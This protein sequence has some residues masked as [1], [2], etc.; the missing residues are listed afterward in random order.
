MES[1]G[2]VVI[3]TGEFFNE[4]KALSGNILISTY[5]IAMKGILENLTPGSHGSYWSEYIGNCALYVAENSGKVIRIPYEY[6]Q[7]TP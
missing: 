4:I 5:A 1:L 2:S 7:I 6:K 3:R